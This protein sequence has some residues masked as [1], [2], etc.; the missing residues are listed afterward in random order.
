[1]D[2]AHRAG[3]FPLFSFVTALATAPHDDLILRRT[4]GRVGLLDRTAVFDEDEEVQERIEARFAALMASPPR[5]PGPPRDEL[6][7][8]LAA[9]V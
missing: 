2:V 7:A 6:L 5:P 1:V 8:R 4:I 9:S 3:D